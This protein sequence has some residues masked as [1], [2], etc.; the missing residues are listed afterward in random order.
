MH[1]TSIYDTQGTEVN[2]LE[3][4]DDL[5]HCGGRVWKGNK[6]Y[7]KGLGIPLL[8]SSITRKRYYR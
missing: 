1:T 4:D 3:I 6:H 7:Y 8:S 2:R 5:I